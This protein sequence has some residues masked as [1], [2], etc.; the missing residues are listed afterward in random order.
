MPAWTERDWDHERDLRKHEPRPT[1][2]RHAVANLVGYCEGL[3]KSGML[4]EDIEASLRRHIAFTLAAFNMPSK[5]E[6]EDAP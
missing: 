5:A 2:Q 3:V 4:G 6:L 1:D